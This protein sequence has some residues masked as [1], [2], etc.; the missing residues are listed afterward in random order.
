L[1]DRLRHSL[2]ALYAVLCLLAMTWPGYAWFGNRIEPY[3]LGLPFSLAWVVAWVLAT[4]VVLTAYNA[5]G[6]ESD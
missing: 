6:R 2:F 5:T 3:V 1:R 4:F